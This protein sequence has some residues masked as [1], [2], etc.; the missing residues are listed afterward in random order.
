MSEARPLKTMSQGTDNY[1]KHTHKNPVQRFLIN[2]YFKVLLKEAKI[3][4][5]KSVLDV[6]CGEGFT[7]N[8]LRK[9]N[10]G[11]DLI[12]VDTSVTA[13]TLGKKQFPHLNLK[14]GS[15]YKLPFKDNTF[16]LVLCLE[17]LEHLED[18]LKAFSEVVRVSKKNC[19]IS[20]PNEP[21]FRGANFIRGK[22]LIK[23]G[24]DIEHIQHW[25]VRSFKKFIK[26]KLH[27]A[28]VKKPFPWSIIASF[29]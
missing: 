23:W 15:A 3:L 20:V 27:I 4:H 21:W 2:R 10:I 7:L 8:K 11:K 5:P 29:R 1:R 24:N 22:N 28:K 19:I 26:T 14:E 9:V 6:G 18:P 12:G 17:V 13:I 16:D 25:S